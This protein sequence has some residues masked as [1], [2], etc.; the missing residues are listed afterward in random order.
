MGDFPLMTKDGTFIINGAER[1]VVS[2]LVRSPGV[3][4]TADERSDTGRTLFAAKLIPNRGAWLEFETSQQG[5]ALGQ[6]RPQAQD[7]GD[8][9][10]A[11][12]GGIG[13]RDPT[14]EQIDEE[15][16]ALRVS[17]PT[18]IATTSRRRW[19]RTTARRRT[20]P[21][22]ALSRLRPGDPPTLRQRAHAAELLFFNPRRYDLGSV[23]RYKLNRK[24]GP[25]CIA[26]QTIRTLTQDDLIAIV[27]E[28]DPAE[29]RPRQARRHRPSRQPPRA[30]ASAS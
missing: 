23:G 1:V 4:F 7:S 26:R 28:H 6:G 20:R 18:P 8:D 14:D 21:D 19:T 5:R 2:Q 22:R 15:L 17:I 24:P 3:Y 29:Q 11:R 10:A 12:D 13:D 9:A 16:A 27:R 30:R 25:R